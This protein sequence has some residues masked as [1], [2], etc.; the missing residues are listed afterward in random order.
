MRGGSVFLDS[1]IFVALLDRT[2]DYHTAALRLFA[3]PP[4]KWCTSLAVVAETYSWFLHRLGEDA[5]RSF[6]LTIAELP[7]LALLSLD[8]GHHQ[9][10]VA[11]LERLRGRKLTYVDASSLV[12]MQRLRV[13]EVWGVDFDLGVE[14]ARVVPAGERS[15]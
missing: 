11:K 5:A 12:F 3:H 6:R 14:G 8:P 10:V 15:S 7:A 4:P 2:D 1:G 13:P 9:R